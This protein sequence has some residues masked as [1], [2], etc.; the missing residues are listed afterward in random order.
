MERKEKRTLLKEIET[1]LAKYDNRSEIS[2]YVLEYLSLDDLKKIKEDLI[3]RQENVIERNH[4]WLMQF[5]KRG[6]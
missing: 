5:K 1:L 2:P 3:A 6:S 4:E